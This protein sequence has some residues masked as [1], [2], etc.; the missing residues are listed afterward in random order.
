MEFSGY[1]KFLFALVFILG[2]IGLAAA[3]ARRMGMGF[4]M[5]TLK[6][7]GNRRLSVVE[8]AP[9]DGRRRLVL[10]RR[11]DTEHL[12]ILSPNSEVVVETGIKTA[13]GGPSVIKDTPVIKETSVIKDTPV[14]ENK[15]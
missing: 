10:V 14:I 12:I 13:A 7:P 5:G 9:L 1:L 15:T 11:D 6:K 3:A 8:T 4:P 2:L